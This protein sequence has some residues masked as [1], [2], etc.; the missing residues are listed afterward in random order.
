MKLILEKQR[1]K[2]GKKK[3]KRERNILIKGKDF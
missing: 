2:K 1:E 3:K